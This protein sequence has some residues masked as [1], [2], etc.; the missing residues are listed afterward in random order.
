M[1]SSVLTACSTRANKTF[2]TQLVEKAIA[3]AMR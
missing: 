3:L 2:F 1:D